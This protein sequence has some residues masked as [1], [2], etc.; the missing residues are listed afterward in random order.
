MIFKVLQVIC[1][2]MAIAAVYQKDY[3]QAAFLISVANYTLFYSV[4][5]TVEE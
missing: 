2:I 1:W 3:A 4:A 5:A